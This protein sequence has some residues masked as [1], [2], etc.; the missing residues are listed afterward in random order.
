MVMRKNISKR[1][2]QRPNNNN[3]GYEIR[4]YGFFRKQN[5]IIK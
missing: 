3:C 1:D 4:Y 5:I 2:V